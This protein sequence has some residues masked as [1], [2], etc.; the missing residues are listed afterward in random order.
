[1]R[2]VR[3]GGLSSVRQRG[4]LPEGHPDRAFHTP[5]RRRGIYCWPIFA[6]E[7]F[8]VSS[9]G[10]KYNRFDETRE[11]YVARISEWC[12]DLKE[13]MTGFG[14]GRK[15][16]AIKWRYTGKDVVDRSENIGYGSIWKWCRDREPITMPQ[17]KPVKVTMFEHCGPA[18]CHLGSIIP[19]RLVL[20]RIDSWVLVNLHDCERYLR[21]EALKCRPSNRHE[22]KTSIDHLEVFIEK[23]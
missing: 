19:P 12:D 13:E 15:G 2:L 1:M 11:Q 20:G 16:Q 5:P 10:P 8:L 14:A 9:S 18:W 22:W 23:V 3:W 4:Y 21:H 6:I 17:S 7:R